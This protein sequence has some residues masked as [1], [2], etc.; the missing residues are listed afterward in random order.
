MEVAEMDKA[1]D[2]SDS[3]DTSEG[4]AMRNCKTNIAK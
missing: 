4:R 3:S 1:D 2:T